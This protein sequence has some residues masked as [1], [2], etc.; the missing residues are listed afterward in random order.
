MATS[1]RPEDDEARG[2]R[3]GDTDQTEA[4][5]ASGEAP[6]RAERV[7]DEAADRAETSDS[8]HD[9]TTASQ[10]SGTAA[11][12]GRTTAADDVAATRTIP[13]HTE[14]KQTEGSRDERLRAEATETRRLA[15]A[16]LG[17]SRTRNRIL[18]DF[19]LLLLRLLSAVMFLHGL[20]KVTGYT[21]FRNG[22]AQN[23][24]GALAPDLFA[25][26]VVAG[27]L[28]LP[29]A[30][31]VGLITRLSGLLLAVMM[32]VIWV[33]YGLADGPF[34][35]SGGIA[36]ESAYLYIVIG[37]AL[38]FTGAGRFSLDHALFGQRA[39]A[40]AVRRAEKKLA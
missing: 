3:S 28:I 9:R 26:L 2:A 30:I 7:R 14:T 4:R 18:T 34:D 23:S 12:P 17:V 13:A 39:E 36:G 10:A 8:A 20:A 21:G 15:A 6:T 33:L 24:F 25:I 27:Q 37:L 35:D 38:F 29:I 16:D 31:A 5:P 32:A 22:V 1:Y 40:R 11:T 19:G